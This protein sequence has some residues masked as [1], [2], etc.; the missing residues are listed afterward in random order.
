MLTFYF[1]CPAESIL[2]IIDSAVV[3]EAGIRHVNADI[4][5]VLKCS[6]LKGKTAEDVEVAIELDV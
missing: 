4:Q 2:D 1:T 3:K 6:R 5:L